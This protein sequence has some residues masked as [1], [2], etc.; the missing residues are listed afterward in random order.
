[1]KF[2][3][4][5]FTTL[6]LQSLAFAGTCPELE[7]GRYVCSPIEED[8][9]YVIELTTSG[10]YFNFKFDNSDKDYIADNEQHVETSRNRAYKARCEDKTLFISRRRLDDKR[11]VYLTTRSE[12]ENGYKIVFQRQF[13]GELK[14]KS[15]TH[16]IRKDAYSLNDL[17][18]EEAVEIN[19]DEK[20]VLGPKDGAIEMVSYRDIG[21]S[22]DS[23]TNY[24]INTILKRYGNNLKFIQKHINPTRNRSAEIRANYYE[25][26]LRIFPNLAVDFLNYATYFNSGS[27]E[28]VAK[29]MKSHLERNGARIGMSF[30]M[31]TKREAQ[32]PTLRNDSMEARQLGITRSGL[33]I[34]GRI[35]PKEVSREEV[36]ALLD[37]ILAESI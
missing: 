7:S 9:T 21:D 25:V 16:C 24:L 11:N 36:M 33:V 4:C 19:F 12:I 5:I 10:N 6:F 20:R 17:M 30:I 28:E 14:E 34:N 27:P 8:R 37:E 3:L 2:T 26:V 32:G 18:N 22:R 23:S 13:N 35:L 29:S 1:M 31:Q 15:E